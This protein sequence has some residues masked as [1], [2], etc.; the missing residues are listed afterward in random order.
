MKGPL[1]PFP[2]EGKLILR[3]SSQEHAEKAFAESSIGWYTR[4]TMA[5]VS[6][7]VAM[8]GK[9]HGWEAL[10]CSLPRSSQPSTVS[11]LAF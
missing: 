1:L 11:H 8:L 3:L 7:V 5:K 9:L 10:P 6:K 2:H 4:R